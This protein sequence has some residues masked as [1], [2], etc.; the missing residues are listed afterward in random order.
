MLHLEHSFLCCR[1]LGTSENT[2][3][4]RWKSWNV[5]LEKNEGHSDWSMRNEVLYRVKEERNNLSRIKWRKATW[6][7][8]TL[9]RKCFENTL[10]SERWKGRE[11]AQKDE[12]RYYMALQEREDTGISK[13][14]LDGS[15][16]VKKLALKRLPTWHRTDYVVDDR[17]AATTDMI[18]PVNLWHPPVHQNAVGKYFRLRLYPI[19]TPEKDTLIFPETLC[20][21]SYSPEM[22]NM[23]NCKQ[24]TIK[25][26]RETVKYIKFTYT[27]KRDKIYYRTI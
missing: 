8:D 23:L 17:K 22:T 6:T 16:S 3:E 20:N 21:N 24:S 27:K 1:N 15:N 2:S 18:I 13:T 12:G 26:E 10:L 11:D 19:N 9:R 5:V 25:Q 14:T 4:L 7:V